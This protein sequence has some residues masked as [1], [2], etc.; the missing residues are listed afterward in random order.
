MSHFMGKQWQTKREDHIVAWFAALAIC[1]HVVESSLPSPIP[2]IK[3]GL[4]NV[5]SLL[6]LYL[7]GWRC[8]AWVGLL[9]VLVGSLI[10]G[11]F[12][13]PGFL[14]SFSGAVA[15]L[16]VFWILNWVPRKFLG[17][18]GIGIASA[19]AHTAAQFFV[20]YLLFIPHPGIFTLLPIFM[21]A[22]LLFGLTSGWVTQMILS[23]IEL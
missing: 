21:T 12:L 14:L 11:S 7:Y 9:R 3:P 8:A 23:K 5:V 1:I 6:V 13:S 15:S 16:C 4:A 19:L 22:A 18:V 10:I 2:G 20:A 17:P